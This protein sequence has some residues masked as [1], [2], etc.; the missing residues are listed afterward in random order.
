MANS[1]EKWPIGVFASID[2]GLGVDLDVA[3]ELG[4]TTIHL[5]APSPSSRTPAAAQQFSARLAKLGIQV[6][7]V[8]AGFEGESYADIPTVQRTI[9]L[10]PEA[11]RQKRVQDLKNII[12]FTELLEVDTTGLHIGFVPHDATCSEYAALIETTRDVCDYAAQKNIYI[13][14]ETGQEPAEVLLEFLH[15][16]DRNNLRV[17]FDPA[18]MILYGCGE[19]IAALK[20]IG[21]YV[22]SIHCK[23]AI[24]S[25]QP[26]ETWGQEMPLGEGAVDFKEYLQTLDAI[27]YT[28]PLTI[29]REIPT[30]PD[31]QKA[32]IGQAIDLLNR[33]KP[34]V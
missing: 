31:R 16:V 34:L 11:T 14:L 33:I 19:P 4:V 10:V 1:Q 2:E 13:H 24:W 12:D 27:G 15:N 22:R 29:E 3:R 17:N 20:T 18:N 25:D 9:G 28:G 6:T 23:D 8:F 7:V 26:G 32:E 21:S 30:E 5:H